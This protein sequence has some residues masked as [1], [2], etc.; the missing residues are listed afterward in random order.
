[1]RLD[2]A[3]TWSADWDGRATPQTAFT[4]IPPR[5]FDDPTDNL[6]FEWSTDPTPLGDIL[7]QPVTALY[8]RE[9]ATV[10]GEEMRFVWTMA[11]ISHA[12]FDPTNVMTPW[13][14]VVMWGAGPGAGNVN[15]IDFTSWIDP[16]DQTTVADYDFVVPA[17][18]T[19][20]WFGIEVQRPT[21]Y[22]N[23]YGTLANRHPA[24]SDLPP[25]YATYADVLAFPATGGWSVPTQHLALNAEIQSGLA[26]DAYW[27]VPSHHSHRQRRH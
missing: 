1:M 26:L 14:I 27:A 20:V 23:T 21:A 8:A 2:P 18:V 5:P 15:N 3:A 17:G 10:P 24:H 13:R 16:T 12:D 7:N 22:P 6:S 4:V 19:S 9:V 11:G 25:N